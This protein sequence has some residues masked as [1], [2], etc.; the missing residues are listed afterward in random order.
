MLGG[1]SRKIELAANLGILVVACLLAVVLI[2][3]HLL[4]RPAGIVD[5]KPDASQ[6]V[7]PLDAS[8]LDINWKENGQTLVLALS[9]SCHFC[10]ESAPFYR[11]LAQ[12]KGSARLVAVLPQPVEDGRNYLRKLGVSVDEVKQLALDRIGVQG[13]PTLI[14]LDESGAVKNSWMGIL[15]PEAELEILK[16]IRGE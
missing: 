6:S 9:N 1:V 13:T 11:K 16:A 8:S 15:P 3:N 7:K 12:T 4:V 10:T 5:A 14:L 2:K